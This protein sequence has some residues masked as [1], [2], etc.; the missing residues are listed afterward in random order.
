MATTCAAG[1][2][3]DS[4]SACVSCPAGTYQ[5]VTSAATTQFRSCAICPAG[6]AS[7][8]NSATCTVCAPGTHSAFAGA[9]SCLTCASPQYQ[10]NAG[11]KECLPCASPRAWL[12]P[13]WCL[14]VAEGQ[15]Y[16]ASTNACVAPSDVQTMAVTSAFLAG[17]AALLIFA[18][19]FA[20]YAWSKRKKR[21]TKI[22]SSK[23]SSGPPSVIKAGAT[24]QLNSTINSSLNGPE[25]NGLDAPIKRAIDILHLLKNSTASVRLKKQIDHVLSILI[26]NDMYSTQLDHLEGEDMDDDVK[27]W[28]ATTVIGKRTSTTSEYRALAAET[29]GRGGRSGGVVTTPAVT[30]AAAALTAGS[31]GAGVP[32]KAHDTTPAI[33]YI[34]LDVFKL[35]PSV[36]ARIRDMLDLATTWDFDVFQFTDLTN[37]HPLLF[38]AYYAIKK[39][40]LLDELHVEEITLLQYLDEIEVMYQDAPYHNHI[41]AADMLQ[42]MWVFLQDDRLK[43]A[44]S[45]LE[46]LAVILSCTIHDVDHPGVSNAFIVKSRHPLALLYSDTSVLEFHHA[47]TGISIAERRQLFHKLP[48]GVYDDLRKLMI[49]LVM[50]TDMAKHFEFLNKFKSHLAAA[51]DR[52][53]ALALDKPD[54]KLLVLE[55]AMKCSDLSNPTRPRPTSL[56]WTHRIMEEFYLQGDQERSLGLPISKFM[57]RHLS[58][59]ENVAKCQASFIDV[60]V[61]PLYQAWSTFLQSPITATMTGNIHA[62]R[63]YWTH[64]ARSRDNLALSKTT[65]ALATAT[66]LP[67]AVPAAPNSTVTRMGSLHASRSSLVI[68]PTPGGPPPMRAP[69]IGRKER[70]ASFAG[71]S[72]TNP[73][74]RYGTGATS[75]GSVAAAGTLSGPGSTVSSAASLAPGSARAASNASVMLV[76]VV[77]FRNVSATAIDGGE[78][79]SGSAEIAAAAAAAI[80]AGVSG[81]TVAVTSAARSPPVTTAGSEA[82][83]LTSPVSP[84]SPVVLAGIT[85]LA[86][87]DE[88]VHGVIPVRMAS[89]LVPSAAG[90]ATPSALSVLSADASGASSMASS[91]TSSLDRPVPPLPATT[92]NGIVSSSPTLETPP[93]QS[94]TGPPSPRI[95]RR[96]SSIG[97]VTLTALAIPGMA[98]M[99]AGVVAPPPSTTGSVSALAAAAAAAVAAGPSSPSAPGTPNAQGQQGPPSG[100]RGSASLQGLRQLPKMLSSVSTTAG[101][102]GFLEHAIPEEDPEMLSRNTLTRQIH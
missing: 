75:R 99:I 39:F 22:N 17:A 63:T 87:S 4:T 27:D 96:R 84:M 35:A 55:V 101:A 28:I 3:L 62:N 26:S 85:E 58:M 45:P 41:H 90:A 98:P 37:G 38:M 80:A 13:A 53:D 10:S 78:G 102:G 56:E 6:T 61:G 19:V 8:A 46:L 14:C 51:A 89:H 64:S 24:P 70:A 1:Q 72:M 49:E 59:D 54:T 97:S 7:A 47:A 11:Q 69:S 42:A 65:D 5:N 31:G 34:A 66:S 29:T 92:T 74:V 95:V 71:S 57:D 76:P 83:L 67:S 36:A 52:P 20:V 21:G 81:S 93:P 33:D 100:R 48:P 12:G 79:G 68:P 43:A 91:Q 30:A 25:A 50:A 16:D 94:S 86:T 60:I 44:C 88:S 23:S 2:Y 15:Y 77:R 40:K 18:S 9:A 73:R 32:L 82:S